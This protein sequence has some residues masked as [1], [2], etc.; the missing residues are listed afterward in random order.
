MNPFSI[1]VHN[2]LP[3]ERKSEPVSLGVPFAR[4]SLKN[5]ADLQ[6]QGP[7]GAPVLSQA[8]ATG[9]WHDGSVRWA[10]LRFL[11]DLAPGAEG[12]VLGHALRILDLEVGSGQET[13]LRWDIQTMY[14]GSSAG[15]FGLMAFAIK[16]GGQDLPLPPGW[17]EGDDEKARASQ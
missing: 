3:L 15:R 16:R 6:M 9:L 12:R 17:E 2:S 14:A 10:T 5:A 11:A 7:D 13:P 1:S 8:T 4:G